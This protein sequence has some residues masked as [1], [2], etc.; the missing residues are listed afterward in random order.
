VRLTARSGLDAADLLQRVVRLEGAI[1]IVELRHLPERGT[2]SGRYAVAR[3][4]VK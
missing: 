4:S 1:L 3:S 2:A